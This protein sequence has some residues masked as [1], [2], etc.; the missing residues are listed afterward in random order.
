MSL[1]SL[2]S[3]KPGDAVG[4]YT[5]VELLGEGGMGVVW[6]AERKTPPVQRVALKVMKADAVSRE[7]SA[8]FN[9]ERQLLARMDHPNIAR[10]LDG[11]EWTPPG[12]SKPVSFV[13]IELVTGDRITEHCDKNKLSVRERLELF[14]GVCDAVQH[15]HNRGVVHRDI[16]PG[17]ILISRVDGKAIPKVIDFG[18]AKAVAG[19][20]SDV[21]TSLGDAVGTL[22][23]MSP[24]QAEAGPAGVDALTD[25]YSL[26]VLLYELL[27]GVTPHDAADL[28]KRARA[29]ALRVMS[30]TDPPK[31]SQRLEGLKTRA[32]EPKTSIV[33]IASARATDA[34]NLIGELQ[35][36]LEW[37]PM[38]AMRREPSSRYRSAMEL[39]DDVRRY[40]EGRPLIAG[41]DSGWYRA[42][43]IMRRH[44]GKLVAASLVLMALVAGGIGTGFGL[45]K[46]QQQRK[47][48]RAASEQAAKQSRRADATGEALVDVLAEGE[49]I[50]GST[51]TG[52]GYFAA[53][54]AIAQRVASGEV[55]L[56]RESLPDFYRASAA[57]LRR[58]QRHAKACE[59]DKNLLELT[60]QGADPAQR[61]ID[62]CN[63][64]GSLLQLSDAASLAL[65][66]QYLAESQALHATLPNDPELTARLALARSYALLYQRQ[67]QPDRALELVD[68]GLAALGGTV[69]DA[70]VDLHLRKG[71]ILLIRGRLGSPADNAAAIEA[72]SAAKQLAA[73]LGNGRTVSFAEFQNASMVYGFAGKHPEAVAIA[74]ERIEYLQKKL[75]DS[76]ALMVSEVA[77][78]LYSSFESGDHSGCRDFGRYW[79]RT[80]A[81]KKPAAVDAQTPPADPRLKQSTNKPSIRGMLLPLIGRAEYECGEYSTAEATL[82]EAIEL[83]F[84]EVSLGATQCHL[85]IVLSLTGRAEEALPL[86]EFAAQSLAKL[87]IPEAQRYTPHRALGLTYLS[88]GRFEEAEGPLLAFWDEFIAKSP[89]QPAWRVRQARQSIIDLYT[90]W[91]KLDKLQDFLRR[92]EV[93]V[94]RH[95]TVVVE[96]GQ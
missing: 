1:T 3:L 52:P 44:R 84:D 47:I 89:V 58:T 85:A 11:G 2:H 31:P 50:R 18:V 42:R 15:A 40:L 27:T 33:G 87:E 54:D 80:L 21:H 13:V 94:S 55:S 67:P 39:A 9:L 74:K 69:C 25:V 23:Y 34:Q 10:V 72:F 8:R 37:I 24:E 30:D 45:A 57:V 95:T 14:L 49:Q 82:R 29:E 7:W 35:R 91:K 81:P 17:N 5:L 28:N 96:P 75:P 51:A 41:P 77:S 66:G 61:A 38:R 32:G 83:A 43:K 78:L 53:I 73:S 60:A 62:L 46:A 70:A 59:Y 86:A 68:A 19:E 76:K 36:E 6:L 16:K 12:Q 71:E 88:L 79:L 26:G 22:G 63:A 92:S 48:A 56:A 64:T 65:A 90:R 4:A 93:V 20:S